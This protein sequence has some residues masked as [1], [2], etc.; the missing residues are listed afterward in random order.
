MKIL[1]VGGYGV[2]KTTLVGAISEI[3]PLTTEADVTEASTERDPIVGIESKT[4]TTVALDF[5]RIT[6]RRRWLQL[7]LFGAPGQPR[8]WFMWD[9][10]ATGALGAVV[11]ADT[12]RLA[13]CFAVVEYCEQRRLPFVIA[14]NEFDHADRYLAD[15]VRDALG[16]PTQVPVLRCDARDPASVHAVLVALAE[17]AL[18][19]RRAQRSPSRKD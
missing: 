6:L 7:L 8:F 12:R 2:G 16:I 17:H 10:L 4:T 14:V 18:A 3:E 19:V 5:G 9:D 13:D 15:E 11:L 1:I